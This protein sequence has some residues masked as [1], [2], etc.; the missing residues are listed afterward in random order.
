VTQGKV[1]SQPWCDSAVDRRWLTFLGHK[2][3]QLKPQKCI[4]P[5]SWRLQ[6]QSQASQAGSWRGSI[7]SVPLPLLLVVPGSLGTPRLGDHPQIFLY[8]P[9]L[10]AL[11]CLS[12]STF[13][14]LLI[15]TH[16]LR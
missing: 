12:V 11:F 6:V 10:K 16:L 8:L 1:A 7:C 5:Q 9:L 3:P 13:P 2:V 14:N 4:V 15:S